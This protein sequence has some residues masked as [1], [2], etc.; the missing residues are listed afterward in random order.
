MTLKKKAFTAIFAAL[1]MLI[2]FSMFTIT[3]S[4]SDAGDLY[5]Y[6][7][8]A[9][10][11]NGIKTSYV[12][13]KG[14]DYD[15][16]CYYG[17]NS[18]KAVNITDISFDGD[19]GEV[20]SI[21]GPRFTVRFNEDFKYTTTHVYVTTDDDFCSCQCKLCDIL[22][23]PL[24]NN[25]A[26]D[27]FM[28]PEDSRQ[29]TFTITEYTKD[30]VPEGKVVDYTSQAVWEADDL[31]ISNGK[32]TAP[33]NLPSNHYYIDAYIED[34]AKYGLNDEYLVTD[35]IPVNICSQSINMDTKSEVKISGMESS[36]KYVELN[37]N[38]NGSCVYT[39]TRD[40]VGDVPVWDFY[41]NR[42]NVERARISEDHLL[43]YSTM[44]LSTGSY[45]LD[46]YP[47]MVVTIK[48]PD[49]GKVTKP[50]TPTLNISKANG[51]ITLSWNA[52]E[53]ATK[54]YIY[55]GTRS[56]NL[57]YYGT[58]T[59]TGYT[60]SSVTAGHTYYYK[61]KAVKT[62]NGTDWTSSYSNVVSIKR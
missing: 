50:G 14:V 19:A 53:G 42:I 27:L 44:T 31:V 38:V 47:N 18:Q 1:L 62:V 58:T 49:A 2:C 30:N 20:V 6:H 57:S 4:A 21:N 54:Y 8:E 43:D 52:V 3:A 56:T 61:V 35:Y 12:F 28:L 55:R 37:V 15:F 41:G 33:S 40:P 24:I 46:V 48:G 23:K 45:Y 5:C 22:V 29:L 32:V 34:Y 16:V 17:S 39:V 10:W 51:K 13:L 26:G 36:E 11:E 9:D 60:N 7:E 59:K 25:G